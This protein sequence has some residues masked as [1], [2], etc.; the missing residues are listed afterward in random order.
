[1]N[2]IKE[3]FGLI[4]EAISTMTES[5][6]DWPYTLVAAL[7]LLTV[8]AHCAIKISTL[9]GDNAYSRQQKRLSRLSSLRQAKENHPDVLLEAEIDAE[10][11]KVNR[12]DA[13]CRWRQEKTQKH[14]NELIENKTSR[15]RASFFFT[16]F[17]L[18]LLLILW[19]IPFLLKFS[20]L[21]SPEKSSIL[22]NIK[23]EDLLGVG[24]LLAFL[25]LPIIWIPVYI[26]AYRSYRAVKEANNPISIWGFS[27]MSTSM[28]FSATIAV[29][30]ETAT[31][32]TAKLLARELMLVAIAALF[33]PLSL[34]VGYAIDYIIDRWRFA[35]RP[36][37]EDHYHDS[38]C[39]PT[40][41]RMLA[42]SNFVFWLCISILFEVFYFEST[43]NNIYVLV[44]FVVILS[45]VVFFS[46]VASLLCII[47]FICEDEFALHGH[48]VIFHNGQKRKDKIIG[49]GL[50]AKSTYYQPSSRRREIIF[51]GWNTQ[52]D[53][54]GVSIRNADDFD[55]MVPKDKCG[56]IKLYAQWKSATR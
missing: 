43:I 42:G 28:L 8:V 49:Y 11:A 21:L 34:A 37:S 41:C 44:V 19:A 50:S 45:L 53:G 3:T 31:K 36:D 29:S 39:S 22:S 55:A 47:S 7:L 26:V 35:N 2:G 5:S 46:I 10:T 54:H 13:W 20:G 12:Y 23:K 48:H 27:W 38:F 1:M 30:I 9:I 40:L 33:V 24:F 14:R 25:I 18:L 32:Y 51:E 4:S 6:N 15:R 17:S 16:L 52:E 56:E